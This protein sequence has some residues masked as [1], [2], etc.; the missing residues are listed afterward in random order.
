VATEAHVRTGAV[1][2]GRQWSALAVYR[3]IKGQAVRRLG[4]GVA[5][6][7][8]SSLTNFA[9]SIYVARTLGAVQ[10]GAFGLAYV[11]YGFALNA[12]RGLS[13]D[14]LMV[15][16]SGKDLS[17]WRR[18]VATCTGT[19]VLVGLAAGVCVLSAAALLKGTAGAAFLALGLTLPGLMLQDSWRYSFFAL[20]RGSQAFLNDT[21]W[22]VA[23][24]PALALLR[25]TGH[26]SVFWFVTAWGAAAAVAAAVGP[27]QARVVPKLSG[28]WEWVS[29]HR[30]LGPRY[31]FEG[32]SN[33]ASIQLRSYGI[34]LILSLAALGYVQA[35]TTLMGPITIL[36]LGM[37]LVLLPE[38]ARVL[39]RSPRRLWPFCMLVSGGLTAAALAWGVVLLVVV[40]RGFGDWLLGP[41]WRPAYPLVLPQMLFVMGQAAAGGAGIGLHALGAARRSLNLAIFGA[42]LMVACSLA[43]AVAAGAIGTIV[44]AAISAWIGALV[45]WWQLR[46]ALRESGKLPADHRSQRGRQA[47]HR[48]ARRPA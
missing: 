37:S 32:T 46:V 43:G 45:G 34:S 41:I 47:K 10:F 23:L 28:A 14:P 26:A 1:R 21:V 20:G 4:W 11:T 6:Q 3:R 33:S 18:A 15:R 19:A 40:P 13:T 38:A 48:A 16:F 25:V 24:L 36:F 30:D 35:A 31:L 9:V 27:L 12:S 44:G 42:I 29:Q 5:D 39:Q 2:P 8:V 7:A 22:A 17:T